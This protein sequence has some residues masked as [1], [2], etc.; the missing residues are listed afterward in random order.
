MQRTSGIEVPTAT[1]AGLPAYLS[2]TSSEHDMSGALNCHPTQS[3][4]SRD[5]RRSKKGTSK[6]S[7]LTTVKHKF[8][9]GLSSKVDKVQE[10]TA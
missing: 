3:N 6:Q 5:A 7:I 8:S 2:V 10:S 1:A 9:H 4:S